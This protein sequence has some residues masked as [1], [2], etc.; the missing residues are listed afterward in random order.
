MWHYL[1]RLF[2]CFAL[3]FAMPSLAALS[4]LH[5]GATWACDQLQQIETS[6]A[7]DAMAKQRIVAF[8]ESVSDDNG[9]VAKLGGIII[10]KSVRALNWVHGL[11][12]SGLW[13]WF[14]DVL[15]AIIIIGAGFA[16]IVVMTLCLA[17]TGGKE[18]PCALVG[19]C[20]VIPGIIPVVA[21]FWKIAPVVDDILLVVESLFLLLPF[22]FVGLNIY[23]KGSILSCLLIVLFTPLA[24]AMGM[25]AAGVGA[26]LFWYAV[27][28][29][30]ILLGL[31]M[32]GGKAHQKGD[33]AVL[34]DGTRIEYDGIGEWRDRDNSSRV[35]EETSSG[36]FREK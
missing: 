20:C 35:F 14:R 32:M 31:F 24:L 28:G 15:S 22:Y 17:A 30:I 5:D 4:F 6:D 18:T 25:I 13:F 33:R 8:K 11:L 9:D 26:Y 34:D 1:K 19:W 10:R 12:P 3:F 27:L 21:H 29:V 36:S 16:L 7:D 2:F 23:Q